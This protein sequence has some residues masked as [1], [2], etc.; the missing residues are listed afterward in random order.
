MARGWL[1]TSNAHRDMVI[2]HALAGEGVV[3]TLDWT[4]LHDIASGALV[5]ALGDWESTEVPPVNLL[6]RAS[7]RRI[8]R[9]RL[10][11][12]FVT[13]L[14]LELE[15]MRG[16]PVVASGRPDWLRRHYGRSSAMLTRGR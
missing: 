15:T 6:Y 13:E 5:Q 2:S 12:E 8:P 16:Q 11:I 1:L 14:F 3:R 10:F 4:N 9:V 7:V